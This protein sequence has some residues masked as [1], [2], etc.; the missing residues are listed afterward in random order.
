[1]RLTALIMAACVSIAMAGGPASV[2][3][4]EPTVLTVFGAGTLAVPFKEI[5]RQ[6]QQR[7]PEVRVQ[8]QFGGSVKMAKQITELH[9]EADILAV[10]DYSVIPKYLFGEGGKPAYADWY[11]GFARNAITF[12]YTDQ[13]K[14]A[15]EISPQNWYR[16]L[17]RKG[18]AIGRSDPDT[19]PSG[20]QTVQMLAL[21]EKF[22]RAPG[23]AESILANAPRTNM[24]DTETSLISAL[25]LGQID[26]LA[27]YRSDAL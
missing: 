15:A 1:M 26:Y 14:F 21:A 9:Q 5:G 24:R 12:V 13:S 7:H 2:R 20:Y 10:T 27:I 23:L 11:A 22:Y 6:F 19:D 17:A 3:A 4:E 8:A 16:V 18:V 25:Q